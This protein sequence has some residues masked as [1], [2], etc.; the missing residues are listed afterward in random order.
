ML[1]PEPDIYECL[2]HVPDPE[3]GLNIVDLGMV[4]Q[5]DQRDGHLRVQLVLTSPGCPLSGNIAAAVE[6]T[7]R[8]LPGVE[9]VLV[10][11][12]PHVQWHPGRLSDAARRHL[13][14][15]AG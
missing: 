8:A 9:T 7:L 14:G 3:L 11:F 2:R 4:E 12:P 13:Q 15:P 6:A 5:V 1:I 10:E